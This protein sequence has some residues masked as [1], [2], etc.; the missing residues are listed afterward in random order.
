DEGVIGIHEK[1]AGLVLR[2]C[3]QSL[4]TGRGNVL[5]HAAA[6]K[7]ARDLN[8]VILAVSTKQSKLPVAAT[9]GGVDVAAQSGLARAS[10][11]LLKR[12]IGYQEPFQQARL[13]RIGA[14]ELKRRRYTVRF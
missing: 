13:Q 14:A 10:D 3:L 5:K 6:L 1:L 2:T 7:Q 11:D 4:A 8:D 9:A 12:W